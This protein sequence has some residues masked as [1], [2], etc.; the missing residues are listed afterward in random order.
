MLRIYNS[1]LMLFFGF[2]LTLSGLQCRWILLKSLKAPQSVNVQSRYQLLQYLGS[3]APFSADRLLY[4]KP[5]D[6]Q[7]M[8]AYPAVFPQQAIIW[9]VIWKGERNIGTS[10]FRESNPH[11]SGVVEKSLVQWMQTPDSE[12][13]T[14]GV[15]ALYLS[16]E[17]LHRLD[18][19]TIV[20]I[21]TNELSIVLIY[22]PMMGSLHQTLW[23]K[24][25]TLEKKNPQRKCYLLCLADF[26][27]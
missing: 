7:R 18:N 17:F 9:N 6:M 26:S 2:V 3:I 8:L 14:T 19:D 11:C 21:R 15:L 16:T 27:K 1:R 10:L 13:D 4:V 25:A 5:I 22:H 24:L 20:D 23:K 12:L